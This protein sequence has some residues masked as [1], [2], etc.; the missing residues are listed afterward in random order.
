MPHKKSYSGL[1]Q[2]PKNWR[3]GT[4]PMAVQLN[5]D[6][7]KLAQGEAFILAFMI[8]YM[9]IAGLQESTSKYQR[10]IN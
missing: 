5:T 8:P 10:L 3:F 2:I 6:I 9:A 7:S 4:R 1:G